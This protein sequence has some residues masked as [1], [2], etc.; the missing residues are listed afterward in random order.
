MGFC[1]GASGR[2]ARVARNRR[3]SSRNDAAGI[4]R[5]ETAFQVR[6]ALSIMRGHGRCG[7]EGLWRPFCDASR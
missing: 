3:G 1:E 4:K 7:A 2:R 6:K 5:D